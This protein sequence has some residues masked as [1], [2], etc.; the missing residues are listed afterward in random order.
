MEYLIDMRKAIYVEIEN[1]YSVSDH[2]AAVP[3]DISSMFIFGGWKAL[4]TQKTETG[5]RLMLK[6]LRI[7]SKLTFGN[8]ELT[9]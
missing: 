7:M 3:G 4:L 5:S 6:S 1:A 8:Y 2:V 9:H